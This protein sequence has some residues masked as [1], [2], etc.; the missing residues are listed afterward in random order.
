MNFKPPQRRRHNESIIP[1]INVVF[2]L[3][4]FFLMTAQITTPKPFE[5]N[6]PISEQKKEA[7]AKTVLYLSKNSELGFD[8]EIGPQ[9]LDKFIEKATKK[10]P[11]K[12]HAD[13]AVVSIEVARILKRLQQ[14][15]FLSVEI[16][17]G[18]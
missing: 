7:L 2:L 11:I 16:V 14:A 1:M 8:G 18:G 4:I 17:I 5:V 6:L 3:L 12:L 10:D 15:G 13:G 9:V